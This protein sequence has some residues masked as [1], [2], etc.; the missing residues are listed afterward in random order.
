VRIAPGDLLYGDREGVLVIPRQAEQHVLRLALE[1]AR[2]ENRV[3]TA[4]RDGMS[5]CEAFST[6]GVM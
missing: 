4:I 3:A 2:T 5:A 1:K 6:F